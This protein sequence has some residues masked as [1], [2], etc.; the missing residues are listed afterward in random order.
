MTLML[1]PDHLQQLVK[2]S[3]IAEALVTRSGCYT[4]TKPA[5]LQ[6]LGFKDY[7]RRVPALVLPVHDVHGRLAL[8]QIRPDHPRKNK[9][10]KVLKYDTPE[11]QK[12]VLAVAPEHRDLLPRAEVPLLVIEGLKKKW[13]VD[14]RLLPGQPVCTVGV[15]GTWGWCRDK[16]PLPDWQALTLH[17]RQV[18]ILYDS[19]ARTVKEVGQA[20][21]A[22]AQFLHDA[23]AHVRQVDFPALPGAK[24]G[25][26]DFLVQGH[27]LQ[28]LLDLAQETFPEP[29]PNITNL[30]D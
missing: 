3:G 4:A 10:G 11:G 19:D 25:A 26:D 1:S 13:S 6:A 27:S 22:L 18:T 14:S 5:Q 29:E 20:R 30:A 9:R 17:G 16:Q 23:G 24:C 15:I 2:G 8:H 7:Q 12:L 21:Q 28:D